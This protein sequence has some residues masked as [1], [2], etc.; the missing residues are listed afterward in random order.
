MFKPIR[1][2][3]PIVTQLTIERK[4]RRLKQSSVAARAGCSDKSISSRELGDDRPSLDSVTT[5]AGALGYRLVLVP[6]DEAPTSGELAA[7]LYELIERK[8]PDTPAPAPG[9][10]HLFQEL[11][12]ALASLF[13]DDEELQ[14]AA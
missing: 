3:H 6:I 7:F 14:E 2:I 8:T 13:E 4:R 10:E 1:R 9:L 12:G 5:W 11:I